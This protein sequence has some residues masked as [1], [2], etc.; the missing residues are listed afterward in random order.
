MY[1]LHWI[2]FSYKARAQLSW[3][4]WIILGK[5]TQKYNEE[6]TIKFEFVH[7]ICLRFMTLSFRPKS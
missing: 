6:F 7:N 2:N 4:H 5:L 3:H 1:V